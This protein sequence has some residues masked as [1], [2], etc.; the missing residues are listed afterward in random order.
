[1][2]ARMMVG[3]LIAEPC[4]SWKKRVPPIGQ[5]AG[6]SKKGGLKDFLCRFHCGEG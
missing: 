6:A 5:G 3:R 2:V 1:M 4:A